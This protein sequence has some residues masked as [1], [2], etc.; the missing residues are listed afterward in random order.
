MPVAELVRDRAGMGYGGAK[1][2]AGLVKSYLITGMADKIK[3][4]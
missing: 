1:P 2:D 4:R 3:V